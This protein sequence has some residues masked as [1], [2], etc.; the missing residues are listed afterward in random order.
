MLSWRV[1]CP[2]DFCNACV[3]IVWK[4]KERDRERE[5]EYMSDF[6]CMCISCARRLKGHRKSYCALCLVWVASVIGHWRNNLLGFANILRC[7][8]QHA[9]NSAVMLAPLLSHTLC[10]FLFRLANQVLE[11]HVTHSDISRAA[12]SDT[13]IGSE[14]VEM[15]DGTTAD[16]VSITLYD[17]LSDLCRKSPNFLQALRD[18]TEESGPRLH[19]YACT[20]ATLN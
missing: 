20:A 1:V 6:S 4:E 2:E 15:T 14:P 18:M 11:H 12:T 10:P 13:T 17:A 9:S 3:E 16:Y 7:S 5:R 8:T 19:A